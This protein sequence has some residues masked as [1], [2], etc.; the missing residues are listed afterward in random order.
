MNKMERFMTAVNGGPVDRPPL[1]TWAHFLSDHLDSKRVVD[2]HLQQMAAYDWDIMKAMNDYRYPVPDGVDDLVSAS[3]LQKFRRLSM[4]EP[5]FAIQ[6]DCL[7]Q[8]RSAIGP[9][10]PILDTI[11]EPHQQIVRNVGYDQTDNLLGHGTKAMPALEAVTETMC[12]YVRAAKKAGADAVLVT[13]NGGMPRGIARGVTREQHEHFQKPFTMEVLKAAEGMVRIL[14][15]HGS[16]LQMDR[17]VDYPYEVLSIADRGPGNPSLAELRRMTD[18]C[19]MG[20]LDE[21]QLHARSLPA[22]AREIDDAFAQAGREK[23]ILAPGC[24]MASFTS[25]RTLRFLREY[26]RKAG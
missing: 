18:K 24:T 26:S 3:S 23:F 21:T 5:C 14:H 7:R 16:Y 11:F 25:N 9:D 12:D 10:V 8:L 13:I 19:L 20:G 4:D 17:L 15:A 1:L 22:L 6:L 2:L